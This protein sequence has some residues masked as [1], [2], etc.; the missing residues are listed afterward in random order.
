ML[1]CLCLFF[2]NVPMAPIACIPESEFE[3]GH[4]V[5]GEKYETKQTVS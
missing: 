1:K 4:D 5:T 3:I 2:K